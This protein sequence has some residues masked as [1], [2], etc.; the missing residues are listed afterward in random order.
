M[1]GF[2]IV[3]LNSSVCVG[4]LRIYLSMLRVRS[5]ITALVYDDFEIMKTKN[6]KFKLFIYAC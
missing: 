1:L 2:I 6:Y 4:T 3:D 5:L